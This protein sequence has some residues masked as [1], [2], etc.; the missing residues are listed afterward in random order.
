MIALYS[1]ALDPRIDAACVSGYFGSR[2]QIWQQPIS[3][4]VFG[5]LEMFGDAE[6]ASIIVLRAL[7][8]DGNGAPTLELAGD[9]GAPAILEP[10]S[11]AEVT[12]E[13]ERL[14]HLVSPLQ[15]SVTHIPISAQH[16]YGD[17]PR[18][19]CKT[20]QRIEPGS[21]PYVGIA[22]RC[23]LLSRQR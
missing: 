23:H 7:I 16:A 19:H 17:T 9:G 1:A 3:R 2:Q 5:L 18:R 10:P 21:Q 4:N 15:P 14:N 12:A 13:L 11:D 8:I 22:D 20:I 6:L